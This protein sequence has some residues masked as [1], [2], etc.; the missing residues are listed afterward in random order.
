MQQPV[1]INFLGMERSDAVDA[2]ARRKVDHLERMAGPLTSCRVVVDL[3]QKHSHQGQPFGVRI[4]LTLP[5]R[6]LC[7]NRVEDEDVY[8]ALRDAFDD[9]E[10]QLAAFVQQRRGEDK[11][12]RREPREAVPPADS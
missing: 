4:D 12:R 7:V 11:Q 1:Q 2:A 6:E 9:L 10:R 3:L 5:G 8:V